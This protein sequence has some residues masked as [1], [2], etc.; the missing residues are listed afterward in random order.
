MKKLILII[1]LIITTGGTALSQSSRG[2][3]FR[4]AFMEN[5]DLDYNLP[6]EFSIIISSE[7]AAAGKITMPSHTLS[8]D[9]RVEAGRAEEIFLPEDVYYSIGSGNIDNKGISISSDNPVSVYAMHYR[10]Y[11]S[12]ASIVLPQEMLGDHYI[13]LA[14]RDHQKNLKP[15]ELVIV[16]AEDNT[17]I[18]ITPSVLTACG[19]EAG[20]PFRIKL[21]EG[22]NYQLQSTHG[23]SA[24]KDEPDLTA[25]EIRSV[26]GMPFAVFS[27]A[28][29]AMTDPVKGMQNTLFDQ[30]YPVSNWGTSYFVTPFEGQGGDPVRIIASDETTVY[31]NCGNPLQI[32]RLE[33]IDTLIRE[34]VLIT[35]NSPIAVSQLDKSGLMNESAIGD[36]SLIILPPFGTEMKSSTV[37][38]PGLLRDR[39]NHYF[40]KHYVNLVKPSD[41]ELFIDGNK[42]GS[43]TELDMLPGYSFAAVELSAGEHRI[44]CEEGF[45]GIAYGFG[46]FD[47]YSYALGFDTYEKF[48]KT[49]FYIPDMAAEPGD[50][51]FVI[52]VKLQGNISSSGSLLENTFIR[53]RMDRS[54]FRP[55]S[56]TAEHFKY[57]LEDDDLVMEFEPGDIVTSDEDMTVCGITGLVLLGDSKYTQIR[58]DSLIFKGADEFFENSCIG[59]GGRSGSLS[60]DACVFGLRQIVKSE[61]ISLKI[62]PNP[63]RDKIALNLGGFSSDMIYYAIYNSAGILVK[64]GSGNNIS[65]SEIDISDFPQGLYQMILISGSSCKSAKFQVVR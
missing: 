6:P 20:R 50:T 63:A 42:I 54:F 43:F 10:E 25:T 28:K 13:I 17:E 40:D 51:N 38:C 2:T 21:N 26:N 60:I 46:K 7:S 59:T 18:E 41:S 33:Y 4:L 11:F 56:A 45:Y 35:S 48:H 1:I 31:F 5:L 32:G 57:H 58:F 62:S 44:E 61:A 27:G 65:D 29:E 24:V 15:S 22:E 49:L 12:D 14:G 53:I 30:N 16:P 64:G 52:P 9:F 39:K 47:A 8:M 37:I 3:E 23:G 34:P 55:E 19:K 36:P